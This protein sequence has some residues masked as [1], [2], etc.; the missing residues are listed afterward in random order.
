MTFVYPG[1]VHVHS[2]YSD[3][4]A[5]IETIARA[6]KKAGLAWIVITD[7]NN[8]SALPEEGF[9][10]GVAVIVGTEISPHRGNHYLALDIKNEISDSLDPSRYFEAAKMQGG[11]GFVAHPDES[12]NRKNDYPPLRWDDWSLNEIGGIEIWNHLS[13]WVDNFDKKHMLTSYFLRDYILKGPSD[14]TLKWWD[15]LNNKYSYIVPAVGGLDVHALKFNIWKFNFEVFP[16]KSS[17]ET[18]TNLVHLE[19]KL[20]KD[21]RLA[22]EQILEA[23]K[24]GSNVIIN[25]FW[26]KGEIPLFYVE[27]NKERA[28]CG[29]SIKINE[30]TKIVVKL[31]IIATL[32][33]IYDGQL[34]WDYESNTLEFDKVDV[35]KYRIE[36]YYKEKPWIFSN[37]IIIT[38]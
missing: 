2:V 7:H 11:F 27:D 1:A 14:N 35:G 17:F 20:S 33:L 29:Q 12:S 22:K 5:D 9:Y 28:Y 19:Q 23:L 24:R 25:R 10:D 38:G 3:G 31:P 8:L 15:D 18:L 16:Y 21:F 34:I 26:H 13:D 4:T 36:V 32:R 30:Y 37:P 6:A